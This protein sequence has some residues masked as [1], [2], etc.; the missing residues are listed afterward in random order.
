MRY[1]RVIHHLDKISRGFSHCIAILKSPYR[2]WVAL[3]YLMCRLI[4]TIEDA[5]WESQEIQH[6]MFHATEH[7]L[8]HAPL[9]FNEWDRQMPNNLTIH[10][11]ALIEDIDGI[12]TL[13][14]ELPL[15]I[16]TIFQETLLHMLRGMQYFTTHYTVN[17]R[18]KIRTLYELNQ[19]CFY[20]AGVV[21][22]LLTK[23]YSYDSDISIISDEQLLNAFHYGF[24]LQKVNILK[25]IRVD[26]AANKIF[27]SS[28]DDLKVSLYDNARGAMCYLTSLPMK[29]HAD[30]RLSCAWIIFNNLTSL[31]WINQSIEENK[32]FVMPDKVAADMMQKVKTLFHD[33]DALDSLFYRFSCDWPSKKVNVMQFPMTDDWYSRLYTGSLNKNKMIDLGM[34]NT[35]ELECVT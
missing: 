2:E 30:Y 25:D 31:S 29:T 1:E 34:L 3:A 5:D 20:A 12:F 33:N 10:E 9:S 18:F 19:Y 11:K 17:K 15:D 16:R 21:G 8:L 7:R 27:I 22:E 14:N 13:Y 4:D 26:K 32:D 6:N 35:V 24:F 28:I 23:L